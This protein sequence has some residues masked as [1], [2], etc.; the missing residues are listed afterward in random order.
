MARKSE[1]GEILPC[2]YGCKE[3][4]LMSLPA[5]SSSVVLVLVIVQDHNFVLNV[6]KYN[7]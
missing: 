4:L 1:E 6:A 3:T 5:V 2:R 7:R